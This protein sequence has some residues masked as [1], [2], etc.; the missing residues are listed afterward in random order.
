[1]EKQ[2]RDAFINLSQREQ[3]WKATRKEISIE[4]IATLSRKYKMVNDMEGD[5]LSDEFPSLQ[6]DLKVTLFYQIEGERSVLLGRL[7]KLHDIWVEINKQ[8][9][10]IDES[11]KMMARDLA[12][13]HRMQMRPSFFEMQDL[14][15][16]FSNSAWNEYC[17][18]KFL[19]LSDW[20]KMADDSFMENWK[21][22]TSSKRDGIL[23]KL[24]EYLKGEME[25]ENVDITI[26]V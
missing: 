22:Y 5:P 20:K 7:E 3:E 9:E 10:E 2:L 8:K 15:E 4:C 18:A 13:S 6:A 11:M 25:E 1:M 26:S 12:A 17:C 19:L 16:D 21:K 23:A 24:Q 14:Y